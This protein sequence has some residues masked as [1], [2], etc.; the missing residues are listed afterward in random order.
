MELKT[1]RQTL[2]IAPH[3]KEAFER[4]RALQDRPAS[5]M[6]RQLPRDVAHGGA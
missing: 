1:A 5:Q 2:P 6:P 4:L 3:R